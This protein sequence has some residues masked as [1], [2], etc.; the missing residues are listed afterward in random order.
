VTED[1]LFTELESAV[2]GDGQDLRADG[3]G[4]VDDFVAKIKESKK[5]LAMC[6]ALVSSDRFI[7]LMTSSTENAI[8]RSQVLC[9]SLRFSR[10]EALARLLFQLRRP[11]AGASIVFA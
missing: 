11:C 2:T 3:R 4:M 1:D 5:L 8:V 10:R 7:V 6:G 9:D